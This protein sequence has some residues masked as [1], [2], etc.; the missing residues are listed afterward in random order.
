MP[1]DAFILLERFIVPVLVRGKSLGASIDFGD[2]GGSW[3]L[4][5]LC[6]SLKC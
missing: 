4:A 5:L 1:L 6:G 3:E 2:G